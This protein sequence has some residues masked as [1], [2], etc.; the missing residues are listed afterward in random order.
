MLMPAAGGASGAKSPEPVKGTPFAALMEGDSV[1][2]S[3]STEKQPVFT[4]AV[5]KPGSGR[6]LPQISA[7]CFFS[8]H[9]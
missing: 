8:R 3:L 7:L 6:Q 5:G 2:V 9:S 4:S 1:V